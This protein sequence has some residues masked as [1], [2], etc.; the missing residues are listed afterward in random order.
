[1]NEANPSN[2]AAHK[3][4]SVLIRTINEK[5]DAAAPT[6]HDALSANPRS[7]TQT[8]GHTTAFLRSITRY[9]N[10]YVCEASCLIAL[11][12]LFVTANFFVR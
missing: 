10:L 5:D 7:S 12:Y 8:R 4:A 9:F 1:M 3:L 2:G 11:A 6:C